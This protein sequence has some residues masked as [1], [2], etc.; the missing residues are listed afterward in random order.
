MKPNP[1]KLQE[2]D[3][4]A[5]RLANLIVTVPAVL[6][7]LAFLLAPGMALAGGLLGFGAGLFIAVTAAMVCVP[8]AW[9]PNWF[10]G[11]TAGGAFLGVM[12]GLLAAVT[13]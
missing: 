2:A 3:A 9:W 6:V 7:V 4:R 12:F 8:P 5:N 1:A 10:T 13:A 11:C